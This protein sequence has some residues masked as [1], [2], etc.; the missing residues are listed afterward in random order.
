[1]SSH[2]VGFAWFLLVSSL[3]LMGQSAADDVKNESNPGKRSELSIEAAN[4]TLDEARAAYLGG[5]ATKGD[6]EMQ[7]VET[8][9]D[10]CLSSVEQ[11]NKYRYWKKAELKV[12]QLTRRVETLSDDLSYDQRGK[13]QA[14][15]AHLDQIHDKLL[16]GVMRK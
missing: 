11:A 10:E 15:R 5:N 16:A 1:M 14:L 2:H 3:L 6:S 8:L 9:A 12:R 13:A 4:R 7:D